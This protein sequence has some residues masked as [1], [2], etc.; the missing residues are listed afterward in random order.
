MEMRCIDCQ[1]VNPGGRCLGADPILGTSHCQ[2]T[3]YRLQVR[4]DMDMD[5]GR[6]RYS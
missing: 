3:G 4:A 2:V 6:V 1:S 5:V